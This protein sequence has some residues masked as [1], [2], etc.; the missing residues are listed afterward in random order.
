MA[1][2]LPLGWGFSKR[3][4]YLDREQG[5]IHYEIDDAAMFVAVTTHTY[6]Q[7]ARFN[8]ALM[9]LKEVV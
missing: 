2:P 5:Q 7:R 4:V 9:F 3:V 1:L 8:Y 6:P